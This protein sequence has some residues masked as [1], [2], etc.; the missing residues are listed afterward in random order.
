MDK[1]T[2]LLILLFVSL[3]LAYS[4]AVF[5]EVANTSSYSFTLGTP[6][7]LRLTE[8]YLVE[9]EAAYKYRYAYGYYNSTHGL[10]VNYAN[11]SLTSGCVDREP[12][13]D[14][15]TSCR[16]AYGWYICSNSIACGGTELTT[17]GSTIATPFNFSNVILCN[18]TMNDS[19]YN[20]L[21]FY[22][23]SEVVCYNSSAEGHIAFIEGGLFIHEGYM[24][25]NLSTVYETTQQNIGTFVWDNYPVNLIFLTH[26]GTTYPTTATV[27]TFSFS[28][29]FNVPVKIWSPVSTLYFH[30]PTT[31]LVSNFAKTGNAKH[32]AIK[33]MNSFFMIFSLT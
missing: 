17:F 21:T 29:N 31:C 20:A 7:S 11:I 1:L 18:S 2:L 22:N 24:N 12:A 33:R 13:I 3:P 23:Y 5:R 28:A 10:V 6:N 26:N 32:T 4:S 16:Y 19:L 9:Y 30:V 27:S 15:Y 25:Y 8:N 14:I